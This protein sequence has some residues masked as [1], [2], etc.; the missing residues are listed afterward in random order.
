MLV[1]ETIA[2]G[3]SSEEAC[4]GGDEHHHDDCGHSQAETTDESDLEHDFKH[5]G[6]GE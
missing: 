4:C 6:C 2:D 5:F 3:G 1:E